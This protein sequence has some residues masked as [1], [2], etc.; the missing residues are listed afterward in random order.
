MLLPPAKITKATPGALSERLGGSDVNVILD[1]RIE[2]KEDYQMKP[3]DVDYLRARMDL[4]IGSQRWGTAFAEGM[5]RA[6]PV[7]AA[8]FSHSATTIDRTPPPEFVAVLELLEIT[9]VRKWPD[10]WNRL[11]KIKITADKS[12]SA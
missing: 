11:A 9:P 5:G 4:L 12:K 7:V 2:I 1:R 8:W 10:R 3:Q 6:R